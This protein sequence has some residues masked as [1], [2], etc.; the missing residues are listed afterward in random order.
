MK[1]KPDKKKLAESQQKLKTEDGELQDPNIKINKHQRGVDD[2][3][4]SITADH[5]FQQT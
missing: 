4:G 5:E 2:I 1:S 3:L